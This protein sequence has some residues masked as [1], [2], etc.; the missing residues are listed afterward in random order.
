VTSLDELQ[1]PEPGWTPLPRL[2]E[3]SGTRSFVS[4]DPGGE[5]LRVAWFSRDDGA[6]VGRAWFGPLAEGPPGHVH[7]GAM[8]ALLDEAMGLCCWVQGHRVLA[9]EITV[10]FRRPLPLGSVVLV[11]CRVVEHRGHR[12]STTGTIALSSEPDGTVAQGTGSFSELPVDRLARIF[13]RGSGG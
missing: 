2:Q 9:R 13:S 3:L 8:A 11:T 10:G 12:L 6:L 4:G 5:R 7:G 1:A